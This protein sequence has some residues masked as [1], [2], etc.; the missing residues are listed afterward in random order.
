MYDMECKHVNVLTMSNFGH[1]SQMFVFLFHFYSFAAFTF[2]Y[3]FGPKRAIVPFLH[4]VGAS[5]LHD[6]LVCVVT[7]YMVNHTFS[8]TLHM[9]K[10]FLD[11]L[12]HDASLACL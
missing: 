2:S 5:H 12:R 7:S 6:I 3:V 9:Y 8:C 4:T 10:V 11:V 1:F